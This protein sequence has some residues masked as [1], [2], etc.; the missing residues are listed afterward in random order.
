MKFAL[1]VK[2][3]SRLLR[4]LSENIRH[5]LQPGHPVSPPIYH[6]P[7][8]D[9]L[10]IGPPLDCGNCN[11]FAVEFSRC[12][13]SSWNNNFSLFCLTWSENICAS[14]VDFPALFQPNGLLGCE[15]QGLTGENQHAVPVF[16]LHFSKAF[17]LIAV[18]SLATGVPL[19]KIDTYLISAYRSSLHLFNNSIL[20]PLATGWLVGWI[21]LFLST[22]FFIHLFRPCP[23]MINANF[24]SPKPHSLPKYFIIHRCG[25]KM[26]IKSFIAISKILL[27]T[28]SSIP[29]LLPP[30]DLLINVARVCH[31]FWS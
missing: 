9:P 6:F 13:P 28:K 3:L 22:G 2:M 14:H 4:S 10:V 29:I 5:I 11:C 23:Y 1:Y 26:S 17:A 18:W 8:S 25:I 7:F 21:P 20:W 19:S 30:S 24:Y 12:L 15:G 27:P 31:K 16:D